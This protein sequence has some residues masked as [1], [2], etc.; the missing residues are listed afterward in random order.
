VADTLAAGGPAAS[1][2]APADPALRERARS[3]AHWFYWVSALSLVNAVSSAMGS[4]WGFIIGLGATQVVSAA[5]QGSANM[6]PEFARQVAWI[7]LALNIVIIAVFTLIGWLATRPSVVAF[8]IGIGLFALDA[9]IFLLLGDWVG[10]AFHGVALFFMVT[11]MQAARAMKRAAG[12]AP[13]T[14]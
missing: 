6:D 9:L 1:P 2:E 4:S 7:G 12:A 11:G 13:A 10:L 3:G 5:A 8:G 14:A